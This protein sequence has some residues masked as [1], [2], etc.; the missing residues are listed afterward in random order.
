MS[1]TLYLRG[2]LQHITLTLNRVAEVRNSFTATVTGRKA[3]RSHPTNSTCGSEY[4]LNE[5]RSLPGLWS[6][7]F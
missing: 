7:P 1:T 6:V 5:P 4:S 3:T 2:E